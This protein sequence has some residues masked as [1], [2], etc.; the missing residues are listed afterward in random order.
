MGERI[1]FGVP[2]MPSHD[3]FGDSVNTIRV[4]NDEED[5]EK[6]EESDEETDGEEEK[7]MGNDC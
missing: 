3:A 6:D 4:S 5:K 1:A 7:K 2:H